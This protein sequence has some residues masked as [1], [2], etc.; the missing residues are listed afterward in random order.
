MSIPNNNSGRKPSSRTSNASRT[1]NTSV[2]IGPATPGAPILDAQ[3]IKLRPE[4]SSTPQVHTYDCL[5]FVI[6][7]PE[8]DRVAVT[9]VDNEVY[10]FPFVTRERR[11][12][13]KVVAEGLLGLFELKDADGTVI[14][15]LNFEYK[16]QP[17]ELF[18][19]QGVNQSWSTRMTTVVNISHCK[20]SCESGNNLIWMS[21]SDLLAECDNLFWG[22]EYRRFIELIRAQCLSM[23]VVEHT[24]EPIMQHFCTTNSMELMDSL[25]SSC[26][27]STDMLFDLY[28]DFLVHSYPSYYMNMPSYR[29]YLKKC[30]FTPESIGLKGMDERIIV[31]ALFNAALRRPKRSTKENYLEFV[32]VA[33]TLLA[34]NPDVPNEK[35]RAHLLFAFYDRDQDGVLNAE[36]SQCLSKDNGRMRID[37]GWTFTDFYSAIKHDKL[38]TN[39]SKN[40]LRLP[41]SIFIRLLAKKTAVKTNTRAA[42][43][44]NQQTQSSRERGLCPQCKIKKFEYGRHCVTID[45]MGRCVEP[46]IILCSDSP[47]IDTG[48]EGKDRY[49]MECAFNSNSMGNV[50]FD[51]IRNRKFVLDRECD[52]LNFFNYFKQL[53]DHIGMLVGQQPKMVKCQSPAVVIGDLQGNLDSL[54]AMERALWRAMPIIGDELIFLGNYTGNNGSEGH[55]VEV[56]AYLFAIKYLCPNKVTLLRGIQETRSYNE[57]TLLLECRSRFGDDLGK[58]LWETVN[59]IFDRLPY[60]ALINEQIVCSSSGFPKDSIKQRLNQLFENVT[61]ECDALLQVMTNMPDRS[62]ESNARRSLRDERLFFKPIALMPNAFLFSC[63]AFRRFLRVN[64]FRYLI[65][66]NEF[67]PNGFEVCFEKRCITIVSNNCSSSDDNSKETR[68]R[69]EAI[70]AIVTHPRGRIHLAQIECPKIVDQ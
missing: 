64:S 33:Y 3:F 39:K 13:N 47:N 58:Q 40:I 52:Q 2:G 42:S 23:Q 38:F 55:G 21:V 4:N 9:S 56:L 44:E 63:E 24:I 35:P 14:R 36:E 48:L 1:S 20:N 28:D 65:R 16:Q 62:T 51:Y 15:S 57:K 66:S 29:I 7:C 19:L 22:P 49:S 25:F 43:C 26:D 53:C 67:V 32:D 70:V 69:N 61:R 54:F 45:S 17:I 50:F 34:M 41:E 37:P 59:G 5:V 8:H 6:I 18:R 68:N 10:W 46:K 27:V 12:W 11:N 30:G 31:Q 60:M